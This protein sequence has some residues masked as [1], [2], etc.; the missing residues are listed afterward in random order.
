ML[1]RVQPIVA[2]CVYH[3]PEDLW[4]IPLFLK[5]VLPY[6]RAHARNGFELVAYAELPECCPHPQ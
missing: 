5:E 6:L 3:K 2:V 4:T 1:K